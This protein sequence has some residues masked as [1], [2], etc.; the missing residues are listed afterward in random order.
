V[1]A[2]AA[3]EAVGAA[4]AVATP[5]AVVMAAGVAAMRVEGGWPGSTRMMGVGDVPG[6][7]MGSHDECR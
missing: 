2:A 1:H 6:V 4:A 5:A 7:V 3:H